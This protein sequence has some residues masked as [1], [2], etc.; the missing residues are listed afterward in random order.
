MDQRAQ[1]ADYAATEHCYPS[2]HHEKHKQQF[3]T[4]KLDVEVHRNGFILRT[5]LEGCSWLDATGHGNYDHRCSGAGLQMIGIQRSSSPVT[6]QTLPIAT[7]L[8][9]KQRRQSPIVE[10]IPGRR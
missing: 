3:G 8:E 10:N 2:R 1:T 5:Y 9:P 4:G 6:P 7:W